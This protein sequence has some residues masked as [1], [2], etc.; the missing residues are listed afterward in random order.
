M[1]P[2]ESTGIISSLGGIAELARESLGLSAPAA[3]KP[4][5]PKFGA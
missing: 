2:M 3:A 5:P 4:Q 1:M